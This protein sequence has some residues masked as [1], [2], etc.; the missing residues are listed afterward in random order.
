MKG[1]PW[2]KGQNLSRERKRNVPAKY[3]K[4]R[5]KGKVFNREWK[6]IHAN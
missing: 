4:R 3:A 2:L 5:D 1:G 6:R